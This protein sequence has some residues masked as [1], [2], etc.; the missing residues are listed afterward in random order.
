MPNPGAAVSLADARYGG[1]HPS[2][3]QLSRY[4]RTGSD[5]DLH[6][7]RWIFGLSLLGA[8]MGQVVGAYQLGI[9]RHLPDPPIGP[10]DSDEVDA[11]DYAFRRAS[12][13]DAPFMILTYG[14]TAWAASAGGQDRPR[15]SP[16]L[17]LLMAGKVA[18]DVLTNLS[19]VREEWGENKALCAWCQTATVASTASLALALP[20]ARRAWRRLRHR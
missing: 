13:P 19:L 17:P 15:H 12:S 2:P 16:L 20:E 8:A 9:L 18:A 3:S 4:L 7:R 5:P 11:S 6:R 10:W 1:A 14:L